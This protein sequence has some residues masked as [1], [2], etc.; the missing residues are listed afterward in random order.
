MADE[1][2]AMVAAGLTIPIERRYPLDDAAQ[3]HRDIESRAT[4]GAGILIP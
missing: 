4:T 3:A 1:L 2:F